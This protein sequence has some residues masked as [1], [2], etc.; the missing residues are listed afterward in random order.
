MI[1]KSM[2]NRQIQ[3]GSILPTRLPNRSEKIPDEFLIDK[4]NIVH[5]NRFIYSYIN[6][7]IVWYKTLINYEES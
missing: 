5:D 7:I 6:N 1:L 4:Q 3:A 2:G